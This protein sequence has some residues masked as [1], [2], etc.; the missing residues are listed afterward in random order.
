MRFF[1]LS[2]FTVY[3]LVHVYVFLKAQ[4]ALSFSI[5]T[6]IS[7]IIAMMVMV[8]APILVRIL[9]NHQFYS[10]ARLMSYTGYV[11]MGIIAIFFCVFLL[12]DLYH[13]LISGLEFFVKTDLRRFILSPR[14]SFILTLIIS[15]SISIYGYFEALA[16]KTEH[17]IVT[18]PKIP[19]NPVKLRIVQ[20]SDVHIGLIVRH[21]R[22]TRIL[23]KVKESE[24]DILVAT[25]DI[26][27][28]QI[29][30][31]QGLAELFHEVQPKYGKYAIPG[32][33]EYYAGFSQAMEFIRNAGFTVLR[34]ESITIGGIITLV[35]SDDQTAERFNSSKRISEKELLSHVPQDKF[36]L[37]LKHRP[38]VNYSSTPF[39]DLQLSGHTHKGQIFPFSLITNALYPTDGGI[40]EL[41]H[42]SFIYVSR[43]SGTW[44][45]PIR[46]LSRPEVTVID[47]V[48]DPE[49]TSISEARKGGR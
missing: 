30:R 28:G 41:P 42:Q 31:L 12:L 37:F 18:S 33:H 15:L 44:G 27:D 6:G 45:P 19:K 39:F 32:N 20:I 40:L 29:N 3:S 49:K 13:I 46:F 34:D 25:G 21:N 11:W 5:R 10:S 23:K 22:L 48:Y 8:T 47:L 4:A 24:P 9:E 16:I 26:V 14:L 1:L 38:L 17:I 7:L 36:I 2:F 35:G 43:G